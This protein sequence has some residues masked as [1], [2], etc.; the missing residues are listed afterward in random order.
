MNK[1]LLTK[2]QE[3]YQNKLNFMNLNN[4][5]YLKVCELEEDEKIKKYIELY[6]EYKERNIHS[7]ESETSALESVYNNFYLNLNDL[8]EEETNNIYFLTRRDVY[9]IKCDRDGFVYD[10][11]DINGYINFYGNVISYKYGDIFTNI[12]NSKY[13]KF[14]AK[15]DQEDFVKN[16]KVILNDDCSLYYIV[17]KN[18]FKNAI[19]Y[20]EEEAIKKAL[21]KKF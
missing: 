12:E 4:E 7:L 3:K 13:W 1:E 17:Q 2:M 15:E 20:G 21:S 6:K 18:F 10:N 5:L 8:K 19:K 14:V 16:N 11:K 9:E